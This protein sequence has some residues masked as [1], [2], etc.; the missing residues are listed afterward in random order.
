MISSE[1]HNAILSRLSQARPTPDKNLKCSPVGGGSINQA[2]SLSF[3]EHRLFCKINSASKF[4]RLFEK[5]KN[6]L[7]FIQQK[8]LIRTAEIIDCF[9]TSD[10]QVLILDWIEEG[11]RTERFWKKFGGQLAKLHAVTHA[12]FGFTEDNYMGSVPQA[13]QWSASWVDF[14]VSRRLQPLV[15]K[16]SATGLLSNE[17]VKTFEKLYEV[18]PT[19]FDMNQK[20]ALLH[21]DLWSGNFMCNRNSEPVLIDPAVYFGVPAVDLGMTTLF[22]GF[23][24]EFYEAYN[25]YTPFPSNYEEQWQICNLYPLLIHLLLFGRSYLH[26]I[27]MTVNQFA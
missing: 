10:H 14:F 23:R 21:G 9:E 26:Q 19:V 5:E 11:E 8:Q 17:L 12:E 7:G 15:M 3:S 6:G 2:F 27:E 16:C 13:N 24:K 4:P 22:G 1:L 20:P 25:Y 18:L